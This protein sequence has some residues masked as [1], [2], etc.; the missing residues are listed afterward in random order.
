MTLMAP[1]RSPAPRGIVIARRGE[2]RERSPRTV[3]YRVSNSELERC[4]YIRIDIARLHI[5][6]R[7]VDLRVRNEGSSTAPFALR[8]NGSR[9]VSRESCKVAEQTTRPDPAPQTSPKL[10]RA[11]N[12]IRDL[13]SGS[14]ACSS[15]RCRIVLA[16]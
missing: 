12:F 8:E 15:R 7:P 11:G 16:L 6:D 3:E 13:L 1:S 5:V 9:D 10:L 4:I 2:E 14:S